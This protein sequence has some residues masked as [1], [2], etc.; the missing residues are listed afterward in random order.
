M[1]HTAQDP[2]VGGHRIPDDR[3]MVRGNVI[4]VEI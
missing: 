3:H 2:E 4:S 1:S